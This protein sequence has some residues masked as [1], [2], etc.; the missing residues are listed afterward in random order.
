MPEEESKMISSA[1]MTALWRS[2][3]PEI[4]NDYLSKHMV[5]KAAKQKSD[6]FIQQKNYP[7][8]TRKISVRAHYF[9]T[10]AKDLLAS[11]TYDAIISFASGFSLLVYILGLES[12]QNI[13]LYDTDLQCIISE[14]KKR[15][16][17]IDDK[18]ENAILNRIQHHSLDLEQIFS[19]KIS[20]KTIFPNTENPIFIL[21]GITYFLSHDCLHWRFEE[22]THFENSAV[23]YDYWHKDQ[24]LQSAIFKNTMQYWS[25]D[26][27]ETIKTLFDDPLL[28]VITNNFSNKNESTLQACEASCLKKSDR[29]LLDINEFYPV[30]V[31]T[32]IKDND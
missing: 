3:E 19:E 14:R 13:K 32:C 1:E 25:E 16:Q 4:S 11:N 5:S 20:L 18:L 9:Y 28:E 26:I 29:L 30:S 23:I 27:P 6:A 22:M 17:H 15:I 12:P 21:E 10:Q 2:C 8:I 24:V 31:M 7:L